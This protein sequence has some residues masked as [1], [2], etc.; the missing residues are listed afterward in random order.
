MVAVLHVV[1]PDVLCNHGK[2][3]RTD[4]LLWMVVLTGRGLP[5]SAVLQDLIGC[6]AG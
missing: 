5:C 4:K 1:L 6:F 2:H 3:A